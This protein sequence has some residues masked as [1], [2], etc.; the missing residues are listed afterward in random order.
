MFNLEQSVAEW[1]REMQAAGVKAP[2]PM[3]E[4]ESHLREEIEQQMRSGTGAEQAFHA[5]VLG[6]G[7]AGKVRREFAKIAGVRQVLRQKALG[8]HHNFIGTEHALL[9]LLREG[10][11]LAARVLTKLGVNLK[12]ARVKITRELGQNQR[13]A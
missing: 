8:F 10:G 13:N 11:G 6:L 1:R 9:G 2:V 5:A 7:G 12:T 4:L 3:E